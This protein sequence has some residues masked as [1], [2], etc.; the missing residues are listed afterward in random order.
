ME[1]V[2]DASTDICVDADDETDVSDED[3]SI[4]AVIDVFGVVDE[5][6]EE[7]SISASKSESATLIERNEIGSISDIG[8][9]SENS[10]SNVDDNCDLIDK[11]I[12]EV[13]FADNN[14]NVV[15]VCED[16][17]IDPRVD[18]DCTEVAV[19]VTVN[20]FVSVKSTIGL[21]ENSD[22]IIL[23]KVCEKFVLK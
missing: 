14:D 6:I 15:I 22:A 9:V 20:G 19:D 18:V 4:L 8:N 2:E 16:D 23:I 10:L 11:G 13:S 21:S 17:V 12:P 3:D 1:N 5:D 7:E